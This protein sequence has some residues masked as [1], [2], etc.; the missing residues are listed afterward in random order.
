MKKYFLLSA[1]VTV[2][3][4]ISFLSLVLI[5][6]SGISAANVNSSNYK[7]V[8]VWTHVNI[9]NSRPQ[10]IGLVVYQESNTSMRNITLSAGLNRTITCN[11]TIRDWNGYQDITVGGLVNATLWNNY[12]STYGA[13]DNYNN[14]YSTA[15]CAHAGNGAGY[16]VNY[17]CTF[18]VY[19]FATNGTWMCNVT[20]YDTAMANGSFTNY[21]TIIPYY[22][23]N[24]TDGIDYGNVPVED[25]SPN[26]TANVTNIGNMPINVTVEG[27]GTRRSDGLAMNC[28]LGGN[29]TID[30]QHFSVNDVDWGSMTA[31][32]GSTQLLSG[33]TIDKQTVLGSP[34]V[35]TTY[36]QLYVSS[37][38]NPG[39]NCTGYVLFSAETP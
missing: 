6:P 35:N 29:I 1:F 15:S 5:M 28:S 12:S 37:T 31:M 10:I 20:A 26:V 22:A 33:L 9:T 21:S 4:L 39:G 34:K 32:T 11:A 7:N 19:Y 2:L 13:P 18:D 36:W 3:S 17:I 27:Y 30:N 16:L 24:V 14:H 8:T 38:N 23:L 25:Y